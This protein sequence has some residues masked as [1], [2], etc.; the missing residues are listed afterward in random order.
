[1]ALVYRLTLSFFDQSFFP[2]PRE[3]GVQVKQINIRGLTDSRG[4]IRRRLLISS[5]LGGRGTARSFS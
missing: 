5:Q 3:L 2:S 1:M 4:E